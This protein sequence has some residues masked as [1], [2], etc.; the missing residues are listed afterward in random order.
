MQKLTTTT[1]KTFENI[2]RIDFFFRV[3][4]LYYANGTMGTVEIKEIKTIS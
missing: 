1:G 3:A 2:I 4:S